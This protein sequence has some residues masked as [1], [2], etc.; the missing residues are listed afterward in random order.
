ML[1]SPPSVRRD[2]AWW[3]ARLQDAATSV[4]WLSINTA[5]YRLLMT[6]AGDWGAGV[7]CA[8][9]RYSH[10]WDDRQ[11]QAS[12]PYRE[13]WPIIKYL[14]RFGSS[15]RR[16]FADRPGLLVVLTDSLTNAYAVNAGTSSS[17]ACSRAHFGMVCSF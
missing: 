17:P 10:Q 11:R 2:A 8:D 1:R 3:L 5:P 16:G 13:L 15:M 4:R 7:W 9:S 12:V 6:D 14:E